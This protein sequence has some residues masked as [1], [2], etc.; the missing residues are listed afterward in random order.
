MA[1]EQPKADDYM[2]GGNHYR[3]VVGEQHWTRMYRLFGPGY[4][5][6][7][8]TGYVERYQDK[9]GIEDLRKAAH[10]IQ[11][12]I[13]LETE[14][15]ETRKSQCVHYLLESGGVACGIGEDCQSSISPSGVTC[16]ECK[17]RYSLK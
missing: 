6:G 14:K 7:C 10:F 16:P 12:L 8:I 4:H 1:D 2:I 9:G 15:L 5:I 3:K 11:K 17:A 13:E